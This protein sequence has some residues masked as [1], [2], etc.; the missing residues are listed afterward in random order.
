M[1]SANRKKHQARPW[2]GV[3]FTCCNVYTR[4]YRNRAGTAYEGR[5]PRCM[6]SVRLRGAP[7]GSRARF[8]VAS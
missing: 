1:D 8:F 6:R 7:G 5:C 2:V 3:K 4:I